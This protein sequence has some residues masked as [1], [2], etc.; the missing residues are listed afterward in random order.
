MSK[1]GTIVTVKDVE[2]IAK[3]PTKTN[4]DGSINLDATLNARV[5]KYRKEIEKIDKK[6]AKDQISFRFNLKL[7]IEQ[8][9]LMN[10]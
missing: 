3:G 9:M 2:D 8:K 5:N 7:L 4:K 6:I 10:L 1:V